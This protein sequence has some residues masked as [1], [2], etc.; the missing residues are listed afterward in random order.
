MSAKAAA[1]SKKDA[2]VAAATYGH[3]GVLKLLND[4][5]AK[6]EATPKGSNSPL[7][8]ACRYGHLNVVSYLLELGADPASSD[9]SGH[10]FTLVDL[11]GGENRAAII[12]ALGG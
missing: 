8:E 3:I 10:D 1:A 6:V 5:G 11:A 2:A 4:A 9:G 7:S 12:A